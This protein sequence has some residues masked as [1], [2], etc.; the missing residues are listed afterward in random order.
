M[1]AEEKLKHN[2]VNTDYY[3]SFRETIK[4]GRKAKGGNHT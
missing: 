1:K 2:G 4:R 3:A